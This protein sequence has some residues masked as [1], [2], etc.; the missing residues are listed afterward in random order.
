MTGDR[1]ECGRASERVPASYYQ[2]YEFADGDV[3][4]LAKLAMWKPGQPNRLYTFSARKV[5]IHGEP[6]T[7][8]S[9]FPEESE[10]NTVRAFTVYDPET[11]VYFLETWDQDAEWGMVGALATI[12][13]HEL[14]HLA[15]DEDSDE[16]GPGHW[17][18]WNETCA[19]A[20][21]HVTENGWE[22]IDLSPAGSETDDEELEQTTLV[23]D[24]G[25]ED[26][27]AISRKDHQYLAAVTVAVGGIIT[28]L[29]PWQG[30]WQDMGL[31]LAAVGAVLWLFWEVARYV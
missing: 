10:W 4:A 31:F 16:T 28:F 5:E 2:R 21:D 23:T 7:P 30:V 8:P 29:G 12:E 24:G 20:V 9:Q 3:E 13:L 18:R 11:I 14:A 1:A 27:R 26:G 17:E 22:D 25:R 6:L 15:V 19:K